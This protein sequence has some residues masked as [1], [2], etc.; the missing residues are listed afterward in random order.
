MFRFS[1]RLSAALC[2]MAL[3]SLSAAVAE[4]AKSPPHW[5]YAGSHGTAHWAR[6]DAGF[7]TCASGQR[8]SPIDIRD[9]TPAALPELGFSYGKVAPAIFNN[10]HTVQ[11]N[12]PGGQ[13]LQVG[14]RRYE[15]LQF[16]FHTPSE[17]K[18]AGKS[19]A[20]VAHF[21]HR[22]AEGRL[23][24]VA[25]LLQPGAAGSAF[26]EVLA[27]LPQRA[28]ETLSVADL[29][30]DLNAL[31]PAQR[32]YYDFEGSL[33]TPPCS[34][35][36]HWMVLREPMRVQPEHLKAFRRLYPAN[37]RPVQPLHGREVRVSQ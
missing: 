32:G 33:T 19:S 6:L 23:G 1:P 2:S 22:D 10:G 29:A 28:G 25:V 35:G 27:H 31:L 14:E 20:M 24:V 21:V 11:V 13:T 9:A 18:V 5:G 34:E 8:Q 4:P 3:C 16:H 36:V 17:E 7:A 15:L 30:L 26:D 37:A 12:V